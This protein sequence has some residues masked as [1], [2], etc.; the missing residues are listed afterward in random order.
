MHSAS[1]W[2]A[3]LAA[4][5]RQPNQ[6]TSI[7]LL[8]HAFGHELVRGLTYD[9]IALFQQ[10]LLRAVPSVLPPLCAL[11]AP[12][13]RGEE[14]EAAADGSRRRRLV[15]RWPARRRRLLL[16]AAREVAC[17]TLHVPVVPWF[18]TAAQGNRM[19]SGVLRPLLLVGL[20]DVALGTAVPVDLVDRFFADLR[21]RELR[22]T[23]DPWIVWLP[24]T[25]SDTD[26][27]PPFGVA[28]C[29][30]FGAVVIRH[31]PVPGRPQQPR[32]FLLPGQKRNV[33]FAA[34]KLLDLLV[35]FVA[36]VLSEE[37][38]EDDEERAEEGTLLWMRRSWLV[39]QQDSPPPPGVPDRLQRHLDGLHRSTTCRLGLRLNVTAFPAA[40]VPVTRLWSAP[41]CPSVAA[42]EASFHIL[43]GL[44]AVQ[45]L[46][47]HHSNHQE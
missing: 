46:E 22:E 9:Q 6:I 34:T 18:L 28:W 16:C 12:G 8:H 32:P 38:E 26:G 33:P 37:E 29:L 11:V 7:E 19:R 15:A 2:T 30:R 35:R 1:A 44:V 4:R 31:V 21:S 23:G 47:E 17:H 43:Q 42:W 14:E 13:R 20:L 5:R 45:S 41:G 39:R 25:D 10:E 3:L 40:H 36:S 27:P 24:E